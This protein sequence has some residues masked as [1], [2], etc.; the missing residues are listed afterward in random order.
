MQKAVSSNEILEK[1]REVGGN[2]NLMIDQIGELI[3]QVGLIMLGLAKSS[4]FVR[5][6]SSR[7]SI[8]TDTAKK[9]AQDINTAIF[10]DLKNIMM[11]KENEDSSQDISELRASSI[12]S[13]GRAG[14][15]EIESDMP[16][17]GEA[18][19]LKNDRGFSAFSSGDAQEGPTEPLVDQLLHNPAATPEKKVVIEP[20]A[21][22]PPKNLPT[23]DPYR[24]AMK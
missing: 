16:T 14:G 24:E 10:Q 23:N 8:D 15:F 2:N 19:A 1:I 12:S 11:G 18:S 6:I 22:Q 17:N 4:G 13:V 5:D 9:V 3:D 21:P 20:K 7:L